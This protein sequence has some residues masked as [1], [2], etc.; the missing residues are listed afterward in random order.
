MVLQ[1]ENP[2]YSDRNFS[3]QSEVFLQNPVGLP[4]S[5]PQILHVIVGVRPGASALTDRPLIPN[6]CHGRFIQQFLFSFGNFASG[7]KLN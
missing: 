3:H 5:S 2:K 6:S 4:I 1:K 7:I